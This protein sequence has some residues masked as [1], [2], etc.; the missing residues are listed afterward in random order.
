MKKT[1]YAAKTL[2]A[3]IDFWGPWLSTYFCLCLYAR[4]TQFLLPVTFFRAQSH[5]PLAFPFVFYRK[6]KLFSMHW[7]ASKFWKGSNFCV[8]DR[9]NCQICYRNLYLHAAF[10]SSFYSPSLLSCSRLALTH[11]EGKHLEHTL[12]LFFFWK[13]MIKAVKIEFVL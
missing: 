6:R 2:I 10:L 12:I 1:Y 8:R 5:S 13:N 7:M 4:A 9:I 11:K 3:F